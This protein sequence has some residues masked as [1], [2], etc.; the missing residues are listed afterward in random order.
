MGREGLGRAAGLI[1]GLPR[2]RRRVRLAYAVASA[3]IY[4]AA[5]ALLRDQ[6]GDDY[7]ALSVLPVAFVGWLFT[8][9][10]MAAVSAGL[11]TYYYY[12]KK[13]QRPA[14]SVGQQ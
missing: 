7:A 8:M 4:I 1:A 10:G 6:A 14:E 13:L 11:S 2:R 5:F 3:A 9:V 12:G